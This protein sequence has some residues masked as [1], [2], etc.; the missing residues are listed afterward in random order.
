MYTHVFCMVFLS[1]TM[2]GEIETNSVPKSKSG[3][4]F[5]ICPCNLNSITT[6]RFAKASLL[7]AYVSIY[8]YGIN[9]LSETYFDS[10]MVSEMVI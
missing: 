10:S 6:H 2:S 3:Q 7:K 4:N 8:N 5:S 9:F 1:K